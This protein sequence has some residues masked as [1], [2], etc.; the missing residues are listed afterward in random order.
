MPSHN[1]YHLFGFLLPWTW[2]ISSRLL[3]QSTA[4]APY[5]GRGVSPHS[6]PSWPWTWSSS[7]RPSCA[8]ATAAPWT[9]GGS[10]RLFL[11]CHSLA[12]SV[13]APDLGRGV[14]PLSLSVESLKILFLVS[15]EAEPGLCP[16]AALL[17]PGCSSFVSPS[18]PFPDEQLFKLA[19]R[20]SGRSW[21]LESVP[22]KQGMEDTEKPCPEAPQGPAGF[23][24]WPSLSPR[25]PHMSLFLALKRPYNL[26]TYA[27][28]TRSAQGGPL[29]RHSR[30]S[31]WGPQYL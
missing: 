7:S 30:H 27:R 24:N 18:S 4:A 9:W 29:T 8:R 5:L 17:F 12:L 26:I 6:H 25:P 14:A 15:L 10:S 28:G 13:A 19:L 16:K 3:Q 31:A 20:N 2:G 1:T 11:C 22:Y 21:R 23:L